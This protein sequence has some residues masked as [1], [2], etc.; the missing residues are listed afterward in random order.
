M[1]LRLLPTPS[2]R[3]LYLMTG[4]LFGYKLP[5]RII[6]DELYATGIKLGIL[7]LS[8]RIANNQERRAV[9]L[10]YLLLGI[11]EGVLI[12]TSNE[13]LNIAAEEIQVCLRY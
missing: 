7:L 2:E 4:L 1:F 12:R 6:L 13:V 3:N 5:N 11:V 10:F 9:N 8:T